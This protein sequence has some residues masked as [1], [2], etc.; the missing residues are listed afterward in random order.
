MKLLLQFQC[1]FSL[2]KNKE[3]FFY[4]QEKFFYVYNNVIT[5]SKQKT[6]FQNPTD[7]LTNISTKEVFQN[8]H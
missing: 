1:F 4:C 6:K 3:C 2:K 7:N 5:N 8:Q